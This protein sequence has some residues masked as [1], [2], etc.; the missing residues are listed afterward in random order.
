MMLTILGC[1]QIRK[2]TDI[3][4]QPSARE[5]YAREF[6]D[7]DTLG[8][9]AWKDEFQKAKN[10]S[11][12]IILPYV[13]IGSY[14]KNRNVVYSYQAELEE[15]SMLKVSAENEVLGMRSFLDVLKRNTDS[16]YMIVKDNG[17][18]E[19]QIEFLI[20]ESG[21]Y[22]ILIQPEIG[23]TGNFKHQIVTSPSFAFPVAGKD[24][25]AI[26]SYW[27]AVRD[28][29]SRS[30]EGV[31]I[32]AQRGTP[33]IA[34]TEGRVSSTGNK[35]LGGK[36]VWLRTGVFGKSLYYAHLDSVL[37]RTGT[38]VSVG[39]TLGLVGN[40]GNARTTQPHLHFGIYESGTG[41]INPLPFIKRT[42]I[43]KVQF[44]DTIA[45][46]IE[47]SATVANLRKAPT[48]KSNIIGEA[49]KNDTLVILGIS[50]QWAHVKTRNGI[51]AFIHSSLIST[52]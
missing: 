36:Q 19:N 50:D 51:K 17:V 45:P 39:D 44:F 31:D 41:A 4:V 33:V 2:V 29:G 15:G 9:I 20:E 11:L 3:I 1:K 47:V 13:E 6:Q 34:V 26:Q 7:S 8:L 52:P 10:D 48:I 5:L 23:S 14:F 22:T 16:T 24:N 32:F 27:G 46:I 30:H 40:T 21:V 35:G 42:E 49:S 37:T 18:G 25:T 38:K 12:T 43:P 28:G